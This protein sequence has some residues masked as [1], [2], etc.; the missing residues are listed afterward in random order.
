MNYGKKLLHTPTNNRIHC[1]LLFIYIIV[2]V[3][4]HKLLVCNLPE[5]DW[6]WIQFH[7]PNATIP[8]EGIALITSSEHI[9]A[10]ILCTFWHQVCALIGTVSL[11]V[12][13][14]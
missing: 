11:F 12:F 1:K 2:F 4:L 8:T 6:E 7:N 14:L 9:L 10:L 5:I 3:Q 13:I